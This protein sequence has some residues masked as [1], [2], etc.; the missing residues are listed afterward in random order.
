MSH[1]PLPE[2]VLVAGRPEAKDIAEPPA[3]LPEDAKDLW[4]NDVQKILEVG[5][6]D[7]IDMAALEAMCIAYAR[8]IQAGRVV[9]SEGLFTQGSVGQLREHPAL[10]IERE[11]WMTFL[12]L[13]EQFGI[14]PISRTRLGLAE[15]GRR[16]LEHDLQERLG[17]PTFKRVIDVKEV[18]G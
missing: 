13:A 4:R 9:K 5:I 7:K 8:A 17:T 3:H 15:L 14:T 6:A 2:P 11:S 10:R 18:L 12:R 16:T 1:R